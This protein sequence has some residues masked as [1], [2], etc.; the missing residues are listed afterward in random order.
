MELFAKYEYFKSGVEV[1]KNPL[2]CWCPKPDCKGFAK[3]SQPEE[4]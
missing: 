2:L 4:K 3:R 1:D